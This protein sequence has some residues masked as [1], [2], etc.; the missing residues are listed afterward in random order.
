MT[1]D[2]QCGEKLDGVQCQLRAGHFPEAHV[3]GRRDSA[4]RRTWLLGRPYD[5]D[6]PDSELDW[7]PG[8]PA[9]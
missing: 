2:E 1:S 8:F 9:P 3:A 6:V 7:A 5:S 4:D